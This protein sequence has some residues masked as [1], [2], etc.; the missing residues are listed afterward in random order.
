MKEQIVKFVSRTG[1]KI[2]KHSPEILVVAGV[3]GII[4][5]TVMACKATMKASA[6]LE[7]HKGKLD[8]IQEV[9]EKHGPLGE[10]SEEDAKKDTIIVC[11][12][13][14]VDFIKLYGPAVTLSLV[15]I[16]CM[17]GAHGIMRKR[18]VAIL[19]AY[20]AVE[21]SY[22]DYRKRVIE[23][24]GEV[25]DREFR[26]GTKVEEIEV[27]TTGKDG[28]EKTETVKMTVPAAPSQYAVFFDETNPDWHKSPDLNKM[29]LLTQQNYAND[30][31]T[32][33]GH[34]FLNE[35]YDMLGVPRTTA[36]AVVGWVKEGETGDGFVDFGIFDADNQLKRDF[37]NGFE[38]SILLDFNV[39]GVIYD[40]I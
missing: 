37:V 33:H 12:R 36:G 3:A 16:G 30:M 24:L 4:G 8:D 1:L 29:F 25:K 9:K 15:G 32:I 2:K 17:L 26:F 31:L 23:Q 7:S 5:G 28:K 21:K 6:L 20:K 10:Y 18:N 38:R 13:T 27:T 34:L 35:V 22:S 11:T 39:D 40:L 19:A 14:A